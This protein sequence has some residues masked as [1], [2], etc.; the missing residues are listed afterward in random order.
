MSPLGAWK[1]GNPA[2]RTGLAAIPLRAPP[3]AADRDDSTRTNAL[4]TWADAGGRFRRQQAVVRWRDRQTDGRHADDD[5]R[6]PQ[7]AFLQRYAAGLT[8]AFVKPG[9]GS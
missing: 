4:F 1:R 8:V 7:P 5:G 2:S 3:H 6:R 9:R